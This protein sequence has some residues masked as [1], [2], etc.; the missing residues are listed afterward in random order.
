M[1]PQNTITGKLYDP[2]TFFFLKTRILCLNLV[3][4]LEIS[5]IQRKHIHL[6]LRKR[7][8]AMDHLFF[9]EEVLVD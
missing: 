6:I 8:Y 9:Y 3:V 4:R 5:K 1:K 2:L 7:V